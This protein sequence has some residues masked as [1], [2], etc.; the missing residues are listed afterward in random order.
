MSDEQPPSSQTAGPH[1]RRRPARAAEPTAPTPKGSRYRHE[2]LSFGNPLWT[3]APF[4]LR[5]FPEVLVAVLGAVLVLAMAS[6]ASPLFL[7]SAGNASLERQLRTA[8][9]GR[10]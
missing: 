7:S 2:P 10:A 5:R 1:P 4:L 9:I 8:Q 3:K 6:A